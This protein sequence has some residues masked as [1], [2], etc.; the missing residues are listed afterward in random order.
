[1]SPSRCFCLICIK[2]FRPVPALR[3]L[4]MLSPGMR[5]V[6]ELLQFLLVSLQELLFP[7]QPGLELSDLIKH[8]V[9]VLL[10]EVVDLLPL[11]GREVLQGHEAGHVLDVH[12]AA[13]CLDHVRVLQ[14]DDGWLVRAASEAARAPRDAGV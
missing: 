5:V 11:F 8:Q 2:P 9:Q 7:L 3:R 10:S 13:E 1:M 14:G 12:Q 6:P 4:S